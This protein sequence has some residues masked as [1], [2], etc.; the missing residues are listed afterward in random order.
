MKIIGM[1]L[2]PLLNNIEGYSIEMMRRAYCVA[3]TA[4]N[5]YMG[6][7]PP[8]SYLMTPVEIYVPSTIAHVSMKRVYAWFGL[9]VLAM[10][11]GV[12]FVVLQ[13]MAKKALVV[14]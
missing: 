6:G 1:A 8:G 10:V 5:G 12:L 4:L 2:P 11:A 7:G 14:P 13:S 3:W 9:Q